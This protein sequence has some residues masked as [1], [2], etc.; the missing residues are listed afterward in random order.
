MKYVNPEELNAMVS[1]LLSKLNAS[2]FS[3]PEEYRL[4]QAYTAL[5]I[6]MGWEEYNLLRPDGEVLIIFAE[7]GEVVRT[8]RSFDLLRILAWGAMRY[9][10][11]ATLIPDRPA[12]AFD[13]SCGESGRVE[14]AAGELIACVFCNGLSWIVRED[15][16]VESE[17]P[18]GVK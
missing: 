6:G 10:P 16:A 9:H 13:C 4:S 8:R 7:S 5:P 1:E 3:D 2:D 14:S 18:L 12:E 11:L 17:E 15:D